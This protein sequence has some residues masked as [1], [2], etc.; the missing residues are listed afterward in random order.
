[1]SSVIRVMGILNTTPDSFSDGGKFTDIDRALEHAAHMIRDGADIID[2]GGESTRP[3]AKA[4]SVDDEIARV[5]PI[6]KV[7]REHFDVEI[8]VDTSKA[9]V[10][11]KAIDAGASMINDVR[12][13]RELGALEACKDADIDICLMH[14]QGEPRTMQTSPTYDSVVE[15]VYAFLQERLRVCIQAGIPKNRLIIDPGFGFGKTLAHNLSL[16]AKLNRF[17]SLEVAVLAGI[18]RKSMI[19][20]LLDDAP[21]D[22]RANGSLAANVVAAMNGANIIRTHDVKQTKEAMKVVTG[23]LDYG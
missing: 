17:K 12:A 3:G 6:V 5:I 2:V 22:Q 13:L 8:S 14:M 19:G 23:V 7:L 10:M 21:V 20:G 1:M 15:D 4:V 18:S 16:L 9:G 11:R